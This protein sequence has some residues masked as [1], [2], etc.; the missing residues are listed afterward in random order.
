MTTYRVNGDLVS[1]AFGD[2]V[3]PVK[4]GRVEL[5]SGAQWYAHLV[6][7]GRLFQA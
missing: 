1:V 6:Q 3:Y 2:E 4:D 5:P 7:S